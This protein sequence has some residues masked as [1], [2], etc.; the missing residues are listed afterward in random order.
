M[1][2]KDTLRKSAA[3]LLPLAMVAGLS[4]CDDNDNIVAPAPTPTPTPAPTSYDAQACVEQEV[5]PG[6]TVADLVVPD[7]LT[8]NLATDSGFPNGRL[9][10]DPV[11][12]VTLAVILLDLTQQTPTDFV[13]AGLNPEGNDADFRTSFPYLAAAQGSPPSSATTATSFNFR[14]NGLDDYDVIERMG[15]PAVST[16]LIST[17]TK[18]AYNEAMPADDI[19]GDFVG[20]IVANLSDIA[21]ALEDDLSGMGLETCATPVS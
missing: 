13:G 1:T 21:T 5:A 17:D 3:L 15:M 10:S 8:L 12:D 7:T 6:L 18:V 19:E 2:Y 9:L 16:A 4:A 20:D 11:I 14:T